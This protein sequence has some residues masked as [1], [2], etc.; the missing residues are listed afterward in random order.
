MATIHSFLFHRPF[1]VTDA[2]P[3]REKDD[4]PI[5]QD[6]QNCLP[7]QS[8]LLMVC[9][10]AANIDQNHPKQPAFYEASL[11]RSSTCPDITNCNSDHVL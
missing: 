8:E 1:V 2:A 3:R 4:K 5:A 10:S 9:A 6:K 7:S 11:A